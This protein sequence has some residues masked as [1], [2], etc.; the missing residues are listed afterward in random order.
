MEQHLPLHQRH[1]LSHISIDH[2]IKSDFS[3]IYLI[4]YLHSHSFISVWFCQVTHDNVCMA[5]DNQWNEINM[6]ASVLA[7][8]FRLLRCHTHSILL[9]LTS[10]NAIFRLYMGLCQNLG[11]FVELLEIWLFL[12]LVYFHAHSFISIRFCQVTQ[13]I[14]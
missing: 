11:V 2:C 8:A 14:T 12:Y 13:I 4:V 6:H 3:K 9:H 1:F 7:V 10:E 5:F